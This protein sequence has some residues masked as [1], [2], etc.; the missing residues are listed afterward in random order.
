[1]DPKLLF[2]SIIIRIGL[3]VYGTYHDRYFEVKYTD[4]DYTVFTEASNH[5]FNGGT[6]YQA[7][8]Y[9]YTPLLALMLLPNI[10]GH[11]LFGK[12]LFCLFDILVAMV[13]SKILTIMKYPERS[14]DLAVMLCWLLNPFTITI[15]SRG[16][17]EAI[18][19]F[20]VIMA[21]YLVMQD[22]LVLAGIFYGLSVHFK[23][24]PVIYGVPFLFFLTSKHTKERD[25]V[26]WWKFIVQMIL[27]KQNVL[28]GIV[29]LT[30]FLL[31]GV[32]MY[33]L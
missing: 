29:A 14:A 19:I 21:L 23:I 8:T 10:F 31:M 28:F 20:L 9:K 24:Y 17:A 25:D 27:V 26:G 16:N 1:M 33:T 18:Q 5:T 13:M 22:R 3:I 2:G 4:I 6:P 7:P 32:A 15:S 12:V 30:T 11:V